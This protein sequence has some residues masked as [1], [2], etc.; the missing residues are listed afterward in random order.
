[1][2]NY[3]YL[4]PNLF[5]P[6]YKQHTTHYSWINV[7]AICFSFGV[8]T[9]CECE[10]ILQNLIDNLFASMENRCAIIFKGPHCHTSYKKI[11]TTFK[12]HYFCILHLS[13]LVS[14]TF[15]FPYLISLKVYSALHFN[16]F[17]ISIFYPCMAVYHAFFSFFLLP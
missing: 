11:H 2:F 6:T 8:S 16:K 15:E 5:T 7:F 10:I 12:R 1:M 13:T 3:Y 9:F 14:C 17:M 4:L